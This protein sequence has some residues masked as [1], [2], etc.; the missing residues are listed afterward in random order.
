MMPA[1]VVECGDTRLGQVQSLVRAFSLLEAIGAHDGGLNLTDLARMVKL[2]PSTAHRLLTT[3]GALRYV[4]FDQATHRWVIGRRAFSLVMD[5]SPS[6]DLARLGKQVMRS[7]MLEANQT[8]NIAVSEEDCVRYVGQVRPTAAPRQGVTQP[9][10]CWPIHTTALGKVMLAFSSPDE[11]DAFLIGASLPRRT[12]A[13]I[14]E[15][16]GLFEQLSII[17]SRGFAIDNGENEEGIRCVA[18]PVFDRKRRVR[19]S[20]SITGYA[21]RLPNERLDSLGHTL[22]AAAQRLSDDVGAVL[23][24]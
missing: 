20:L 16:Q 15:R 10:C 14:V 7:L 5:A 12:S 8:V 6:C 21:A 22:A 24:V 17:R 4:E 9:G 1:A 11:I 19:A 18:A 23:T 2:A 3:M 13:S